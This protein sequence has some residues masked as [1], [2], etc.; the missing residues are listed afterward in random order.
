MNAL[1][2]GAMLAWTAWG[3]AAGLLMRLLVPGRELMSWLGSMF[4]GAGGAWIGGL[5]AYS[6]KLGTEPFAPTGWILAIVG[7]GVALLFYQYLAAAQRR[8]A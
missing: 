5:I 3:V 7:A 6:P 8:T 1:I 2:F 4:A